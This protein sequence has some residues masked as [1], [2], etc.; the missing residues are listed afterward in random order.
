MGAKL[1]G[2]RASVVEWGARLRFFKIRIL[3]REPFGQ[4]ELRRREERHDQ[5]ASGAKEALVGHGSLENHGAAL[6]NNERRGGRREGGSREPRQRIQRKHSYS[7]TN[8]SPREKQ[9]TTGQ[10][11]RKHRPRNSKNCRERNHEIA[12]L[13]TARKALASSAARHGAPRNTAFFG[14]AE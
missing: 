3:L 6:S 13:E 9:G 11:K 14:T 2:P 12:D 10:T 7:G 4:D 8:K 5:R 1:V